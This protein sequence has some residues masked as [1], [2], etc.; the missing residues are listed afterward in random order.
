MK[1]FRIIVNDNDNTGMD[2]ISL[3][4]H[5]AVGVNFLAFNEDEAPKRLSFDSDKHIITGVVCLADTPIYRYNQ[6]L[7]EYYVVFDADVIEK[8]MIKYSK[9][10]LNNS[11]DLQH[12][13][14][15]VGGVIM[16]ESYIYNKDRGIAP[17]EFDI[18]NGSWIAS[19]KVE[20]ED[21]WNEIKNG[22]TLNGF[23]LAGLF[24][25]DEKFSIKEQEEEKPEEKDPMDE[26]IDSFLLS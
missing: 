15:K 11:V 16:F 2:A 18:P 12:N 4:D 5:P 17:V 3:V 13:G 7:G 1:V 14:E 21:I 9:Q 6:E 19:F 22:D 20:N 23:S 10:N 25:F 26:F 24:Q 8:M